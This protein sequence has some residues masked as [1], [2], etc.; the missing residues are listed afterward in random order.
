M[1][2]SRKFRAAK[3]PLY[4]KNIKVFQCTYCRTYIPAA[5]SGGM[6]ILC[7]ASDGRLVGCTGTGVGGLDGVGSGVA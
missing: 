1:G 4:T 7:T 3:I 6:V 2:F 5:T